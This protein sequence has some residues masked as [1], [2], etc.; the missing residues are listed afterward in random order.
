M[1]ETFLDCIKCWTSRSQIFLGNARYAR[2][3]CAAELGLLHRV[4][5]LCDR[6][7]I[8]TSFCG[9][10]SITAYEKHQLVTWRLQA[11]AGVGTWGEVCH[12]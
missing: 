1:H 6:G 8:L 3:G 5:M 11:S 12:P 4:L 10:I 7:A 9:S 2:H